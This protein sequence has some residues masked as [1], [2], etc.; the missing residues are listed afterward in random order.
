MLTQNRQGVITEAGGG[1]APPTEVIWHCQHNGHY[2]DCS[3]TSQTRPVAMD[4]Q[5]KFDLPPL[6]YLFL[7]LGDDRLSELRDCCRFNY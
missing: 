7:L 2:L 3:F 1:A 4:T 5:H 6:S